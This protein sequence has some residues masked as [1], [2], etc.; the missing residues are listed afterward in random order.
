MDEAGTPFCITYDFDSLDDKMVTIRERDSL[1]Q[2]RIPI[3][4]LSDKLKDL[5]DNGWPEEGA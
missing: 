1:G 4:N 3:E 2:I 5:M